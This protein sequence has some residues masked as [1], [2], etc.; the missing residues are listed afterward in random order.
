M[1][2]ELKTKVR[3]LVELVFGFD[4]GQN[5]KNVRKNRE[6]AEDLKVEYGYTYLVSFAFACIQVLTRCRCFTV[7]SQNARAFTVP[8]LSRRLRTSCGSATAAMKVSSSMS[9]S[10][11]FY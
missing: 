5:R 8:K 7:T 4:S 1:R 3:A 10:G 9:S 6:L 11:P 2:G